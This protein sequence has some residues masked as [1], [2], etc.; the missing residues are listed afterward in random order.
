V[1]SVT[2]F[3]PLPG[4]GVGFLASVT[5]QRG[6]IE[7]DG[8]RQDLI[9]RTRAMYSTRRRGFVA[10]DDDPEEWVRSFA[11]SFRSAQ[12]VAAI[13]KDTTHKE[14]I[15]PAEVIQQLEDAQLA[16]N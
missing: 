10:I 13:I 16:A 6:K 3:Q 9:D 11:D 15:A 7:L 8:P 2:V 14:L 4:D 5:V 1:V 12:V